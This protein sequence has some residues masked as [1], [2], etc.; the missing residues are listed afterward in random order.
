M[1]TLTLGRVDAIGGAAAAAVLALSTVLGLLPAW[2]GRHAIA[3]DRAQAA[4]NDRLTSAALR[5][6]QDLDARLAGMQAQLDANPVKLSVVGDL[7]QRLSD[8]VRLADE[9]GLALDQVEPGAPVRAPKFTTVPIKV[10]GTGTYS[11]LATFFDKLHH[12]RVDT[13][14]EAFSINVAAAES[15]AVKAKFALQ[16]VWYAAPTDKSAVSN[17]TFSAANSNP[18]VKAP[19]SQRPATNAPGASVGEERNGPAGSSGGGNH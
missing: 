16:V 6:A 18:A 9:V 7:N 3:H 11:G 10:S 1:N 2:N 14:V 5:D 19:P 8:F 17:P 12:T 13:A 15:D 4:E